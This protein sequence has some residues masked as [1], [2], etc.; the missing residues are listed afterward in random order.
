MIKKVLIDIGHPA[1]V[2]LFKNIYFELK[3]RGIKCFVTA[4]E[5][6]IIKSLLD[7]YDIPYKNIGTK[8]HNLLFKLIK[9]V[10]YNYELY[11]IATKNK[12]ELGIGVSF[13]IAHVSK[14]CSM[15]SIVFDDDN[16]DV[17]PIFAKFGLPFCDI[18][19]TPDCLSHENRGFRHLTYRGFHELFYLHPNRFHPDIKVLSETGLN[20][21]EDYFVLR[22]NSFKAYHDVSTQGLSLENKMRLIEILKPIGKIFITTESEIDHEFQEYKIKIAPHKIHS[23]LYYAKMYIGDSQTM[24]SEAAILGTPALKCNS[25]AGKLSIPNELENSYQL[26]F[27]F[28][29]EQFEI[30]LNKI[31]ELL[32]NP[33]LKQ[34]WHDR[35]RRMLNDKIDVT[36]FLVWF[37]EN[38]PES[39]GIIRENPE[40]YVRFK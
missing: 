15:K 31:K 30:M 26:C 27:S 12:I 2:H 37:I 38:Y 36:A 18:N 22:F 3:E 13:S 5:I 35:R 16:L 11:K 24:T 8:A 10:K 29:P 19:I 9:H 39:V 23:L 17:E 4:K 34:E 6:E 14:L 40:Y 32:K 33:R 21:G 20:Y 25:F 28:L 7:Y 1:H